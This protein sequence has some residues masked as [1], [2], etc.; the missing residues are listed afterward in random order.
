MP[1]DPMARA[2]GEERRKRGCRI[3]NARNVGIPC[4][5]TN[6]LKSVLVAKRSAN[7]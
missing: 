3:G 1:I 6:H 4:K 2:K 7:L 5:R